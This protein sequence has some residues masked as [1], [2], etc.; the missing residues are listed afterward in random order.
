[1]FVD[2][3]EKTLNVDVNI[4]EDTVN[5]LRAKSERLK[6]ILPVHIFGRPCEM[7]EIGN[8]T[9]QTQVKLLRVLQEREIERL[10]G[11]KPIKVDVRLIAATKVD[12]QI[13]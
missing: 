12:Y 5:Q 7:D 2:I 4:L 6:A 9:P 11:K 1:M 8:L 3:D 13:R 10:G